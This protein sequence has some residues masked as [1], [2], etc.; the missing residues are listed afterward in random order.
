MLD[1]GTKRTKL[2]ISKA[3]RILLVAYIASELVILD[4][5]AILGRTLGV[6]FEQP[7]L[8]DHKIRQS[9][10]RMQSRGGLLARPRYRTFVKPN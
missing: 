1:S 6:K 2:G 10:Q 9:E 8:G 3:V 4:I 7:T 5:S